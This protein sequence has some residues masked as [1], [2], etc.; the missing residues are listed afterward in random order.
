[1]D[2]STYVGNGMGKDKNPHLSFIVFYVVA[3]END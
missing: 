1:M 2:I 3:V